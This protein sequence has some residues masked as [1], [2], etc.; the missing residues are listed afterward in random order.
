MG[1][2]PE[3]IPPRDIRYDVVIASLI[4]FCA[5]CVAGYAA[6]MQRQQVR[7]VVWPILEFGSN[8]GPV[9]LTLDNKGLGPAI[10]K[11][12][13][14]RVDKQPVKNWLEAM[15]KILGPSEDHHFEESDMTGRV[16][17]AGEELA[18]FTP[19]DA[20]NNPLNFDK[21]NPL[22]V[23]L[24]KERFRI[25]VEICYCSTLGECWTLRA[26][27]LTPSETTECRS[28]PPRSDVT[29]QQ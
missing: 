25:S 20:N 2:V 17:A 8:N 18:I 4:G 10:I 27:G 11:N 3:K 22:W 1:C 9:R 15:N 29:F 13:I 19:H 5:L 16:L 14:V 6:Y 23:A 7:A 21:S 12:A 26:D 24:N 28:C